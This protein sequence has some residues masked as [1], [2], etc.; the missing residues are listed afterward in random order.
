MQLPHPG[1][2]HTCFN[3]V[4][5]IP[6][7]LETYKA[8]PHPTPRGAKAALKPLGGATGKL[9]GRLELSGGECAS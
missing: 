5:A 7:Q 8:P 3:I 1:P 9:R 6:A 2:E 4:D